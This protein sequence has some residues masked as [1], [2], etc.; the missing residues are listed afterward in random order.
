MSNKKII[1][2]FYDTLSK[3][4]SNPI[5][6]EDAQMSIFKMRPQQ[7]ERFLIWTT[8]WDSWK[9]LKSY[10]ESDQ[11]NFVSTHTIPIPRTREETTTALMKELTKTMQM[12][13]SKT[14][15]TASSK[16]SLNLDPKLSIVKTKI[17]SDDSPKKENTRSYS[18]IQLSEETFS[19]SQ[20]SEFSQDYKNFDG[21]EATYSN[22]E[23]PTL[24]FSKLKRKVPSTRAT[25]HELKIEV[26][27][28]SPKG[29]SFRSRSK[30]ISLSGSLLEDTV[31]FDYYGIKFDVIIINTQSLDPTK[32]RIKLLA[33]IVENNGGLTHRIHFCNMTGIQK[34]SLKSLLED[35]LNSQ[36]K[37][38]AS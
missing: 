26:V 9:Q 23:K 38:I 3:T 2:V 19:K 18:N 25:Q 16:D 37:Y 22:I 6:T 10:L 35:Y 1:W 28:I 32:N 12:S 8:T 29:K 11:K 17:K 33:S 30:N 31:P 36:K 13:V 20:K 27:L 21:N 4:Q 5:S 14:G 24:D 7:I 15:T 34:K